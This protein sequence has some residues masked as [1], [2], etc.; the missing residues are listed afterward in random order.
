M[1][2]KAFF[3]SMSVIFF[4]LLRIK[5]NS[6]GIEYR[7]KLNTWGIR[8]NS[9]GFFLMHIFYFEGISAEFH[10]YT[11]YHIVSLLFHCILLSL[12]CSLLQAQDT[13]NTLPMIVFFIVRNSYLFRV[14]NIDIQLFFTDSTI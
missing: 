13:R 10:T 8:L 5:L 4:T 2:Y 9:A 12:L 14:L 6:W 1:I 7:I 11:C 3:I